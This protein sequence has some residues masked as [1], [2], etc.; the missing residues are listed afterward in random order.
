MLAYRKIGKGK[1][2]L[3]ETSPYAVME[4]KRK[5][6]TRERQNKRERGRQRKNKRKRERERACISPNAIN[7]IFSYILI[8]TVADNRHI[9]IE[10]F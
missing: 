6:K 10:L 9:T 2:G 5:I 7:V 8:W 4:I 1:K 3:R